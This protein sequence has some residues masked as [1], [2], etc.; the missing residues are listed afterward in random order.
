MRSIIRNLGLLVCLLS[1]SVLSASQAAEVTGLIYR[2]SYEPTGVYLSIQDDSG[3]VA[4]TN[5][6]GCNLQNVFHLPSDNPN[7]DTLAATLYAHHANNRQVKLTLSG[8]RYSIPV[9]NKVEKVFEN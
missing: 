1:S 7:Y 6:L 4:L 8:C 3:E 5:Q 2:V 9:I